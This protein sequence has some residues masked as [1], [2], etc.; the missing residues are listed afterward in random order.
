MMGGYGT[1]TVASS[2]S[3]GGWPTGAVVTIAVLAALLVAGALT[4]TLRRVHHAA[5]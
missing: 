4:L 3:G 5:P 2:A 1:G